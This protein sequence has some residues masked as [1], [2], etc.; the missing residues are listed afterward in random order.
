MQA[1]QIDELSIN[2]EAKRVVA[3]AKKQKA[4]AIIL[5]GDDPLTHIEVAVSIAFEA[6]KQNIATIVNTNGY[7]EKSPL[8]ACISYFDAIVVNIYTFDEE[9]ALKEYGLI[10]KN[11]KERMVEIKRK[12]GC[13]MEIHSYLD[14][15]NEQVQLEKWVHQELKDKVQII[16]Q[17]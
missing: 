15:E 10:L 4:N 9:K 13:E 6:R 2:K 17:G 12:R 7:I 14:N 5:T 16:K 8:K 3:D 1:I 11:I